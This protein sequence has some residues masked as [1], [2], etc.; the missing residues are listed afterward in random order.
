MKSTLRLISILLLSFLVYGCSAF[1]NNS[2][3][4]I[5]VVAEDESNF[6]S[7][8]TVDFVFLF[9]NDDIAL[10]ENAEKW[11][12]VHNDLRFNGRVKVVTLRMP[13]SLIS[14]VQMPSKHFSA[15]KVLA[16]VDFQKNGDQPPMDLTENKHPVL[17]IKD[18]HYQLSR[19]R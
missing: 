19:R 8:T 13:P 6:N 3:G 17:I 2:V 12:D 9:N 5:Q 11:F 1:S 14:E 4:K 16:Y 15:T 18:D 10:P 7:V